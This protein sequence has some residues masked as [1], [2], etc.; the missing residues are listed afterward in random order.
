MRCSRSRSVRICAS[1]AILPRASRWLRLPCLVL[2]ALAGVGCVRNCYEIEMRPQAGQLHRELTGWRRVEHVDEA[3]PFTPLS[4]KEQQHLREV[5]GKAPTQATDGKTVVAGSFAGRLP[6]DV[7]GDGRFVCW[8]TSLGSASFYL[9]RFRGRDD[10]LAEMEDRFTLIDQGVDLLK[11]WVAAAKAPD[12]DVEPVLLFLNAQARRDLKNILLHAWSLLA[13]PEPDEKTEAELLARIAQYLLERHYLS[14]ED[15]PHYARA[16][17]QRDADAML[18]LAVAGLDRKLAASRSK[19]LVQLL[20]PL[21]TSEAF[22]RSFEEFVGSTA[23]YVAW[24]DETL[25]AGKNANE[26]KPADYLATRLARV[27]P[28]HQAMHDRL[29]VR[30]RLPQP[31]YAGNGTWEEPD[32]LAWSMSMELP[33]EPVQS[34]L[35][36]VAFAGWTEPDEDAQTTRFG[37]VVFSGDTLARYVV[38]QKSLTP[39]EAGEWETFLDTLRPTDNVVARVRQFRFTGEP[40]TMPD[41]KTHL[42]A[43]PA[44]WLEKTLNRT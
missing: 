9:E 22:E 6:R 14:E 1:L 25:A 19:P 15:V 7:G 23:Q 4:G 8:N 39:Q 30:L 2:V 31:P 41:G 17:H 5:Y 29:T 27:S 32:C 16:I 18:R 11:D 42:S 12:A 43:Q 37:R 44:E 21:A 35:P 40:E 36:P 34:P 3:V 20:P 24:R 13:G 33:S 28:F 26:V 10:L 38:W